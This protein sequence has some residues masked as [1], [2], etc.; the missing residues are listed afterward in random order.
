[1]RIAQALRHRRAHGPTKMLSRA[2][3]ADQHLVV[4]LARECLLAQLLDHEHLL[5]DAHLILDARAE[6]IFIVEPAVSTFSASLGDD[7]KRMNS[8]R[9]TR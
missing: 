1:M 8:G 5:A 6:H 3:P 7:R 2:V 4:E 9:I